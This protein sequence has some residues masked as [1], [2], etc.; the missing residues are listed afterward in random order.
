MTIKKVV[1]FLFAALVLF[2]GS[3]AVESCTSAIIRAEAA[4]QG[5][6]MLWKNRDT[7]FLS[8]K[9]I[10][11][12]ESPY[13]YMALVN[14]ED[15]SGRI[16][17]AGLNSRGFAIMN[18]VAYNLPKD[19][20][21]TN[22]LE[23]H[24][25]ADALRSC[26]SVDDFEN[27]LKRNL[28]QSLGAWTNFG[29]IDDA[30][31]AAI[32]ETHNHGYKKFDVSEAPGKYMVNTNYAR[33]G[34]EGTGDGYLRFNRA[35]ELFKQVPAGK[36]SHTTILR[37]FTRDI[38]HPLLKQPTWK[39]LEKKSATEPLWI[40]NRDCI[41]RPYTSAAAVILGKKPGKPHSVATMWVIMGEPVT[42][43]ALPVFVEAHQAPALLWE[44]KEAPICKE[45]FR[46]KSIIRPYKEKDRKHY[47]N[48]TKLV[49]KEKT[50]FLPLLLKTEQEIFAQ[51]AAFLGQPHTAAEYADFQ[52]RM[53]QKALETMKKIK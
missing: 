32:F 3:P 18:T 8:N 15:T 7:S 24:I 22:N 41:N 6:P 37:N 39:D 53:A 17:F 34:K 4:D 12:S 10:Y 52:N 38:G 13:S 21:E 40:Y 27:Y 43:V 47:M 19:E 25:M 44:G 14:A 28:G 36:I 31:N 45:A 1:V 48:L 30:G 46:L 11:V 50:G 9:V 16:V 49:N 26:A 33:S 35:S 2:F 5:R 29:V 42:S 51:T 23:G 20:T